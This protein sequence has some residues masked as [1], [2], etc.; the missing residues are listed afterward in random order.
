LVNILTSKIKVGN[1]S[2]HT[3][4]VAGLIGIPL[5][6]AT[7][8]LLNQEL[9]LGLSFELPGFVEETAEQVIPTPAEVVIFTISPAQTFQ[10][11]RITVSGSFLDASGAQTT[12]D[13]GF[14]TIVEDGREIKAIGSVGQ[15]V[16]SFNVDIPIPHGL[17]DG[18]YDLYISDHQL[19]AAELAS[20]VSM[21]QNQPVFNLPPG[22]RVVGP[23]PPQPSVYNPAG[24]IGVH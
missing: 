11:S 6:V 24:G 19:T 10:G 20:T 1:T 3:V 5:G 7:L 4:L 21:P 13:E 12:V 9:G 22:T 2:V 18:A 14:Y 16:S 23:T 8:Y 15:N 17:R